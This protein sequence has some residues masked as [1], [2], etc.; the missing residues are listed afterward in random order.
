[1][2]VVQGSCMRATMI[3]NNYHFKYMHAC[4]LCMHACMHAY[5]ACMHAYFACMHACMRLMHA[6]M[7]CMHFM[8]AYHECKL[9]MRACILCMHAAPAAPAALDWGA[10]PPRPPARGAPPPWTPREQLRQLRQHNM[11]VCM[12]NTH[13]CM[14]LESSL[15]KIIVASNYEPE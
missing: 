14:Y 3:S 12:H 13:A 7:I 4:I 9:R 1:M 15:F 5:Y 8:Q 6:Y 2:A 10:L 11:H